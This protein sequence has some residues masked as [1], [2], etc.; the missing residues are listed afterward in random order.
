[1]RMT[2]LRGWL[3]I[4]IASLS[5]TDLSRRGPIRR[6]RT[7]P[8]EAGSEDLRFAPQVAGDARSAA[9]LIMNNLSG[10]EPKRNFR[11]LRHE[12]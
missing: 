9:I 11:Q 5:P 4:Y 8:Y 10:Q 2:F 1:M 3:G 7:A 12:I 6:R